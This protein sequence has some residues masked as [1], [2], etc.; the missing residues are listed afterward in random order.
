M[1]A[2]LDFALAGA[3][4]HAKA[5]QELAQKV[6]EIVDSLPARVKPVIIRDA[7]GMTREA[8]LYITNKGEGW[9]SDWIEWPSLGDTH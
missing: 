6:D 7:A 3:G 2:L 5:M 1:S 9:T 8:P 4:D